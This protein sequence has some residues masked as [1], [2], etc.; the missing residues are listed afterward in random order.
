MCEPI[1]VHQHVDGARL[2]DAPDRLGDHLEGPAGT[3]QLGPY[4]RDDLGRRGGRDL[5]SSGVPVAW[6]LDSMCHG[7]QYG[8]GLHRCRAWTAMKSAS[9]PRLGDAGPSR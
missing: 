2:T 1:G 9:V 8:P 3:D 6:L 4:L 5:V 7:S